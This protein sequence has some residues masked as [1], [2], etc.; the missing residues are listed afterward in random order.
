M[1]LATTGL[2]TPR[3]LANAV[4]L[5]VFFL[6]KLLLNLCQHSTGQVP[7][8]PK[9]RQGFWWPSY[10]LNTVS[11]MH[12]FTRHWPPEVTNN[13]QSSQFLKVNNEN[14]PVSHL[15]PFSLFLHLLN[16]K[17]L[18]P[19]PLQRPKCSLRDLLSC[20]LC[21]CGI[22]HLQTPSLWFDSEVWE[23]SGNLCIHL[24]FHLFL[25]NRGIY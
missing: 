13:P 14:P 16:Q 12:L 18:S 9:V 17:P 19:V 25:E 15:F 7:H 5:L 1:N 4:C 23:K 24:I 6:E 20:S 22:G 11:P 3:E 8:L 2:L 10:F 21:P